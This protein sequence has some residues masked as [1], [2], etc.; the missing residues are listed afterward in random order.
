MNKRQKGLLLI[1]ENEKDYFEVE[2]GKIELVGCPNGG[3][4]CSEHLTVINRNF[5]ISNESLVNKDYNKSIEALRIAFAKSEELQSDSCLKCAE[6]FRLAIVRSLE[7]IH[8]DLHKMSKSFFRP[9]RYQESY[10][11]ASDLLKEFKNKI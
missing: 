1:S 8:D 11:L 7:G 4:G 3:D 5:N 2:E 6:L 9:K 10:S